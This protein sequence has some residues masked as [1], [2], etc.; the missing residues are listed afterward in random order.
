ME[1]LRRQNRGDFS[2]CIKA[3]DDVDRRSYG[4]LRTLATRDAVG[5]LCGELHLV[6]WEDIVWLEV[7]GKM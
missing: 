6:Q 4:V 1:Y 7:N 5:S 3:I 2:W